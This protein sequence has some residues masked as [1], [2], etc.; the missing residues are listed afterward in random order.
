M[1]S[2]LMSLS[3]SASSCFDLVCDSQSLSMLNYDTLHELRRHP[4]HSFIFD[5][6]VALKEHG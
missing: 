5:M 3:S 2:S 1:L 4:T 6:L